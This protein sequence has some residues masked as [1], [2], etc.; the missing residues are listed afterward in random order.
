[1]STKINGI[2]ISSGPVGGNGNNREARSMLEFKSIYSLK[3]L[4]GDKGSYKEWNEKFKNSF[5]QARPG[6]MGALE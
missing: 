3:Q 1:M 6:T 5:T 4:G 2:S